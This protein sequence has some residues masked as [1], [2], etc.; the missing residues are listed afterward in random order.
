MYKLYKNHVDKYGSV[1]DGEWS[2]LFPRGDCPVTTYG[3]TWGE[4]QELF[5]NAYND[6]V[7]INRRKVELGKLID[8]I[9]AESTILDEFTGLTSIQK[10]DYASRMTRT[11]NLMDRFREELIEVADVRRPAGTTEDSFLVSIVQEYFRYYP[12]QEKFY[13]W[14]TY[15]GYYH[16]VL[17]KDFAAM[18]L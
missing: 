15:K 16:N 9:D 18:D 17:E 13:R 14:L 6:S 3:M 5:E 2:V 12:D 10:L 8:L 11:I 7:E 4:I 1:S